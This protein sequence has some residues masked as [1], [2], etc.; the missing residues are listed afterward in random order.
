VAPGTNAS[1][2]LVPN[3]VQALAVAP[4]VGRRRPEMALGP[5][6]HWLLAEAQAAILGENRDAP[7]VGQGLVDIGHLTAD[8]AEP[9][10]RELG[11]RLHRE[12]ICRREMLCLD[13]PLVIAHAHM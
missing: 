8:R 5:P 13:M 9:G 7:A 1:G 10:G 6:G 11:K 2:I 3:S 12:Q 4:A